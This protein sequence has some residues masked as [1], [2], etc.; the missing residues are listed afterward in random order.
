MTTLLKPGPGVG[1]VEHFYHFFIEYFLALFE[2]DITTGLA[3]NDYVVRDCGPMNVWLDFAFGPDAI[4]KVSRDEFVL[5]L[6]AGLWEEEIQ[7]ESFAN[8][9]E[10]SVDVDRFNSVVATFREKFM[11]ADVEPTGVT[12]IDRRPPPAFYTDGRAEIQGGGST[13]RSISNL[14]QLTRT[15]AQRGQVELVDFDGMN[16]AEQL[17]IISK[18][19]VLVGQHGAG[20]IHSLFMHHESTLVEFNIDDVRQIW[21]QTLNVGT[22]RRYHR[23]TIDGLHAHLDEALIDEVSDFVAQIR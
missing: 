9:D 11:M 6:S 10:I 5:G 19:K 4:R 3:G 18:T 23:F 16:P 12:I 8:R 1:S 7:L 22:G 20:L 21:F 17:A 15:I 2:L 14:E 13:R